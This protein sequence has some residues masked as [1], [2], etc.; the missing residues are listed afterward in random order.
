MRFLRTFFCA[1]AFLILSFSA[2]KIFAQEKNSILLVLNKNEANLVILDA[3]TMKV[4]G[5]VPVGDSPHEV[6]IAADGKRA[7]V[8]NYGAQTPGSSISVIDLVGRKEIKRIDLGGFLRPHGI[9]EMDGNIYF[10][11]E[12]SRTVSRYNPAKDK[13]DWVMGTGQSATHMLVISNDKKRLFTANIASDTVTAINLGV[14]PSAQNITQI[15]VGKQPEAI[16]ISPDGKE[17]W[18]GLNA[19]GA[20]DIVDTGTNKFKE[21]IKLGERPYRVEFT[22]DGKRVF[23]TIPNTK[24]IVVLDAATRK[25]IK[26]MKLESVPLGLVFSADGR[27]AFVSAVQTDCVLKI[28]AEKFEILGRAETGNAPDGL[29]FYEG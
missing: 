29:A 25:E 24:E 2:A 1:L 12:T 13:I 4:L 11:S 3:A 16:D 6:V 15:A 18:V 8:A 10:T 17:V 7:F 23:A 22:P 26:R 28:D 20:I 14:P 9:V 27:T 5:K 21:K 19:E